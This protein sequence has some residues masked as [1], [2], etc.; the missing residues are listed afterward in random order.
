MTWARLRP[1]LLAVLALV[2]AAVGGVAAG[3]ALDQS[4]S[5]SRHL[6]FLARGTAFRPPPNRHPRSELL[7]RLDASL[8]L[9]QEQRV[10]VDSVLA[11]READMRA[12]RDQVRPRFDSIAGRTRT[13]LLQILTPKQRERFEELGRRAE[14]E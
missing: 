6:G 9:T 11:R 13:D 12:L 2:L 1:R 10:R 5:Q 7:D 14:H 8:D 4:M 3:V